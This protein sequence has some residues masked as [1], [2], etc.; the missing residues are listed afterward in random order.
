MVLSDRVL[1]IVLLLVVVGFLVGG[2]D[3]S[4]HSVSFNGP[5][6]T[7]AAQSMSRAARQTTVV[8]FLVCGGTL[9]DSTTVVVLQSKRW[10]ICTMQPTET[11]GSNEVG[12]L[13]ATRV[14]AN[15]TVS[16]ALLRSTSLPCMSMS[17]TMKAT[18]HHTHPRALTW[19]VCRD[20]PAN[21]LVGTLPAS[22]A[23]LTFVQNMYV[24]GTWRTM[25]QVLVN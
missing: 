13:G 7:P 16:N 20:L 11:T 4:K 21:N 1:A 23:N 25:D 5:T 2:I 18:L 6:A 14:L 17:S 15:S 24:S 9:T 10:L 12:G 22:I 19:F 3:A 8:R